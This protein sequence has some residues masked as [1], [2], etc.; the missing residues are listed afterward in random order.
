MHAIEVI[1]SVN[2]IEKKQKIV[3]SN[4]RMVDNQGI[5]Y[6]ILN[7]GNDLNRATPNIIFLHLSNGTLPDPQT[8]GHSQLFRACTAWVNLFHRTQ[9][10]NHLQSTSSFVPKLT[11]NYIPFYL[12]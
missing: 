8:L 11:K 9:Q 5:V 7:E 10:L 1:M 6:T 4:V 3:V 12:L 2:W